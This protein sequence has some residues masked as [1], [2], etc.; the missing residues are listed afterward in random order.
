MM[1]VNITI[2]GEVTIIAPGTGLDRAMLGIVRHPDGTI[3]VNP[4]TQ[5]CL[6]KSADDGETWAPVPVNLPDAPGRQNQFSLGVTRDGRL[7]LMHQSNMQELF[8]SCSADGGG[9]WQTTPIDFGAFAPTAPELPY[10]TA[11]DDYNTFLERPDGKLMAA[12]GLRYDESYHKDPAK[13]VDGLMRRDVDV[14]G[15]ILFRTTDGGKTWGDPTLVGPHVF[16]VGYALD[17]TDPDRMLAMTR[18][19]GALLAGEDREAAIRETGCPPD[20]PSNEGS[21]YKNGLLLESSD[22]GRCFHEVPGGLNEYYGHRGTILWTESNVVVVT[23]QSAEWLLRPDGGNPV[24][25]RISL[26][27]GRTWVDGTE[28]GTPY[29]NQSQKFTLVPRHPGHSF[30]APTVELAANSFL[31]VYL[32]EGHDGNGVNAVLWQLEISS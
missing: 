6:Y 30:T 5:P 16:E 21:I 8:V 22:G 7:W 31:T 4:Q 24:L 32:Y 15:Q 19:Q 27:G 26:D 25:A 13:R 10:A 17:P 29:M 11:T 9:T 28:R 23:H 12:A 2:G 20:T 18:V 1:T 14:G 3:Y